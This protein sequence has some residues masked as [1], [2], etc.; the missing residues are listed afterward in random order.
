MNEPGERSK[1]HTR[2]DPYQA[3][4][5]ELCREAGFDPDSRRYDHPT[6]NARGRP[7]WTDYRQ[8]ARG[9]HLAREQ[10]ELAAALAIKQK[11]C[12]YP[13]PQPDHYA[14]APLAIVGRD[15]EPST[16]DQMANCMKV[17]NVVAGAICAD[18]HLGYAQPVGASVAYEGQISISGVGYDIACGNMAVKLDMPYTAI[19]D[20]ILPLMNKIRSNISF[21][22][23]RVNETD[24]VEHELFDSD[25][26]Q[27]SG[28]EDFKNTARKQLGTIGG[29]NHYVDIFEDDG[30]STWIGV[31]FGSRGLGHSSAKMYIEAAGGKDGINVAPA[32]VG[33][34]TELG[35]R[36]LAAMQLAGLYA[37]AGREW[38]V[39]KVRSIIGGNVLDM[40]HNHHNFAWKEYHLGRDVWVVRKGATPAFPGQRGFVGGSMGDDAVIIEGTTAPSSQALRLM[41]STVHGAGRLFGRKEAIRRY[42]REQMEAWLRAQDVV[43]VGGEVDESPMAYRRLRDVLAD[44]GDTIRVLNT[45]H[46]RGVAMA[47]AG[48][49]DPYK[50]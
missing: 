44:Q 15:H 50:D 13:A 3:R 11:D 29:G 22:T 30:G 10:A 16:L 4:A 25:L 42:T 18:G 38:V 26:W 2:A 23:G 39:E 32:V 47:G 21:G 45:L 9:E 5:R 17:G 31:H 12:P 20:N 27:I 19:K 7:A 35:E 8:A 37:Y 46:P 41:F 49:F 14:H 33:E 1:V 24:R 28:R 6:N 43:L 48:E 36:Y 34:T 40:V